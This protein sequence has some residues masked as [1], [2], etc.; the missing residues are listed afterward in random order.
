MDLAGIAAIFALAGIPVSVLLGRWQMRTALAQTRESH[1]TAIELAEAN[2]RHAL[3]LAR[4]GA[5]DERDRWLLEVRRAEY[6]YFQ[7]ALGQL[8]RALSSQATTH[9]ELRA[10]YDEVHDCSHRIAE[11]GPDEVHDIVN[12]IR[13]Q[14]YTIPISWPGSAEQRVALWTETIGPL[15]DELDTAVRSAVGNPRPPA[16]GGNLILRRP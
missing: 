5:E 2:H 13:R 11:V 6:R 7:N 16:H 4:R 14:C 3:E 12:V 15:R 10:A 1:R 8:R 9:E